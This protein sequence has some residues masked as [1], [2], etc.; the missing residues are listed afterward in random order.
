[1]TATIETQNAPQSAGKRKP[2]L[3]EGK[4]AERRLGLLLIAPA[5]V[6][7]IVVTGYPIVYAFWLSLQKASLSAPGQDEFIGFSNYATVLSDSYWWTAFS[8]TL[9]ITVVSVMIELVL[10]M[11]I[12]L[13]MHRTLFGK[14]A[15]R[16]LVLIPYGIVTVVAAFSWYY[17]W[18]PD[19]GYL[20]NLL[21]DGTA[22]LTEQW[23]SLAVIVLAEVWKTTPFMALLLLAGLALVPDDLLKAAQMDGAGAWT[24]LTKIILPLMKPAILVALLF[25]TLDA[26]RVFDNIYI[27]TRGSNNTYSVSMLGYDNLFKAFNLGVGSAISVL[28]FLCVAIIALVFIKL[29]GA[30]APGSDAEG[31]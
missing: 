6:L 13:V 9:G 31:R 25:R 28:I 29:F 20:A 4:R 19:T 23:P 5:V 15:I 26:F 16:T 1:M 14:G 30:S 8:V 7:M 10:G 3:S 12:A 2:A 17:A 21:P 22:P 27:L 18:T 24:R 11:A